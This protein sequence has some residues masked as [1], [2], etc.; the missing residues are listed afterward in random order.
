ML[1]LGGAVESFV[2]NDD[3]LEMPEPPLLI[4]SFTLF[5][6]VVANRTL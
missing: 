4:A 3:D 2:A 5:N 1:P 6:V